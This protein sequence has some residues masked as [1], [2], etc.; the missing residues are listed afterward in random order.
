[1][2]VPG[3]G[4]PQRGF[5]LVEVVVALAVLSLIMLATVTAVRSFA[6]T[7]M[8]MDRMVE[9]IDEVRTVSS[10]LRAQVGATVQGQ[11][12][13]GLS[14][15][16]DGGGSAYFEGTAGTMVWKASVL[17]GESFGGTYLLKLVRRGDSLQLLWREP[18]DDNQN[19]D[20]SAAYSR[21]LVQGVQDFSLAFRPDFAGDWVEQW[22][23]GNPP[24]LVRL[25]IK[26][27]DRYWPE[28]VMRLPW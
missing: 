3:Q 16:G 12:N 5:T 6:N 15:G 13:E 11:F 4:G 22:Q 10:F 19:L 26:T 21:Q 25:H 17:F 18:A 7:Q 2:P 20:W 14:L 1:M 28:L 27:R 24:A 8:A 23:P 9:R